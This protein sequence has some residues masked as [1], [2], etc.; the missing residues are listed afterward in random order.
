M[1]QEEVFQ[2]GEYRVD[3]L[4][5][6]LRRNDVPV[7]LNRRGFDVL[8]YLVRNPGRVVTKEEL[9]KSIWPDAFVDENN[10]TQ[11]M[12][13]LRKAL[14]EQPG[15]N[16]FI[17][18]LPGRGYQFIAPVNVISA[19]APALVPTLTG[20][21]LAAGVL[22]QRRTVTTSVITEEDPQLALP[23]PPRRAAPVA[24]LAALIVAGIVGYAAWRHFHPTPTSA[25][26]VVSDFQ[27]TTGDATFDQTLARA[28]EIDLG[29]SPYMDVMSE[30]EVVSALR[31]MGQ[32]PDAALTTDLAR[33]LCERS[34]RR[35]VLSGSVAGL[36]HEYLLTLVATDCTTGEKLAAA[37]AE[38]HDKD[39]VLSALDTVADRVR[40]RLGE[41]TNSVERFEVPIVTAT[42]PSLEALK[43]YSLA[44]S[45]EAQGADEFSL[46]PLYQ[47]AV[48]L[49][50]RFAMAWSA[51]GTQYYNLGEYQVASQNYQKAFDLS[52]QV[53]AKE[54]LIIRARYYAEGQ[55]DLEQGIK[56]YRQWAATYPNDWLPW[57]SLSN[58]YTR[59]GQYPAAIETGVRALQLD[60]NR[61]ITYGVLARAYKRAGQ[62]DEAKQV[63]AEALRRERGSTVLHGL[64]YVIAWQQHDAQALA[65]E[66]KWGE[67]AGWY[68]LYLEAL[69]AASEG[70]YSRSEQLFHTAINLADEDHLE[71]NATGMAIDEA[72]M[73][74]WFGLPTAAKATLRQT[75][76]T[77]EDRA[78][79]VLRQAELGD[80]APATAFIAARG[81][82]AQPGTLITY[83]KIPLLRA[84][85]AMLH[86]KPQDAIAALQPA[87][88]YE[89]ASYDVWS[90]RAE[91]YLQSKQPALAAEQYKLILDNPGVSFGP[92]YPLA[93]LGLARAY[94]MEGNNPASRSEYQTFLTSWKDADPDLPILIAAKSELSKLPTH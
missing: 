93:H 9:L 91:A 20:H 39:H 52:D 24:M 87:K 17:A 25:R 53:S 75:A 65:R 94:A 31:F 26:V 59:L 4:N 92:L 47:R 74:I 30:Q 40:S 80:P 78:D 58:E 21:P 67:D 46:I 64:L 54:N 90:E 88:P 61:S 69:A 5:R 70:R 14:E 3:P 68:P 28:L 48:E 41:S 83:L 76:K 8:L 33:Q 38:A 71:E 62:Y 44:S 37:K 42:T 89:M 27:N 35:V 13:V 7:L 32:K 23:P 57:A 2:F 18:T 19:P 82:A 11:S 79:V 55:Q 15:Q 45:M 63:I 50:P 6:T 34:N 66:A 29:Q 12:S 1:P 56:V 73:Q 36:G 86:N 49:D 84:R 43:A 77:D 81:S 22:V 10:L 16:N 60:P 72:A 85:L 51:L